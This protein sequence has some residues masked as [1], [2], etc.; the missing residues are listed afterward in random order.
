MDSKL[1]MQDFVQGAL[2]THPKSL[3]W[4][5]KTK[6][7][8]FVMRVNDYAPEICDITYPWIKRYAKKIDADFHIITERKFPHLPVVSEKLQIYELAQQ[9]ENDWN[10]YIDSDT[11]VHPECI[12]FTQHLNKDTIMQFGADMSG[13]RWKYDRFFRRDGR[14]IGTCNWFTIFS[15][16][17]I[18][19]FKPLDDMTLEEVLQSVY[20]TVIEMNCGITHE[21]LTDDYVISRNVAKYGLKYTTGRQILKDLGLGDAN[22]FWHQYTISNEEKVKQL[23]EV[24]EKWNLTKYWEKNVASNPNAK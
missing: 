19:M 7:T 21:H 3:C 11:L 20:P 6:K 24:L 23:K 15:D 5:K 8:I 13:I 1:G 10:I 17:C 4:Q 16:W 22:F 2:V 12:D 18:E 9:M 14:Y